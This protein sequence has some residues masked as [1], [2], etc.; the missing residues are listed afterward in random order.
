MRTFYKV[1]FTKLQSNH[2]ILRTPEVI[3]VVF[4]EEFVPRVGHS[5]RLYGRCLI[6]VPDGVCGWRWV[7]TSP[8]KS[9]AT[10]VDIAGTREFPAYIIETANSTY[11][12]EY[13]AQIKVDR[14]TEAI[15]AL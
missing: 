13:L 8:V 10:D 2:D 11:A 12:I 4:D 5:Y 1:K 9:V 6:K 14:L 15:A 7:T 3:G